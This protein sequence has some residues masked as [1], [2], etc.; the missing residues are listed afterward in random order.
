M[1]GAFGSSQR[2]D[3]A[4]RSP[5]GCPCAPQSLRVQHEQRILV[6]EDQDDLLTVL[7]GYHA[8]RQIKAL[9]GLAAIPI[10]AVSSF[11]MKGDER[12]SVPLRLRRLCAQTI[13]PRGFAPPH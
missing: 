9:P 10:I 5:C 11:A 2:W 12:R 13:Q 7:D 1:A 4:R 6:V 8:T 3:R